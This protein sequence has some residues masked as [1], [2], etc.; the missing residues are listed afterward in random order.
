M[1]DDIHDP[2]ETVFDVPVAADRSGEEAGI[3]RIHHIVE[4][5]MAGDTILVG[6]DAAQKILPIQ[7]PL[8]DLD[9]VLPKGVDRNRSTPPS[10]T[11]GGPL[12]RPLAS[13]ARARAAPWA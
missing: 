2:V 11:P 6:Q 3:E 8:L 13:A 7:T 1:E 5:V 10:K 12:P 9:K 4:R